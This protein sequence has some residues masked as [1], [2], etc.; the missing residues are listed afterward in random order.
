MQQLILVDENDLPVGLMEKMKVHQL[1][2]MHRAFSVFIFNMEGEML[3]QQIALTKY[4][5]GGLWTN[6]C[7]SHPYEGQEIL[8][9]AKQRL[10]EEMGFTTTIQK[11]FHFKYKASFE[12]G[13]TENEFDH[14]FVGLYNGKIKPDAN[15]V[16]DYCY[17]AVEV[18]RRDIDLHPEKYT[19]WF[20]IAFPLIENY[21]AENFNAI[22]TK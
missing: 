12:N 19:E 21:L 7:C 15:E 1:G 18:V 5:S 4:H 9:A 2:I 17:M 10:F 11:A 22:F 16:E 20:K 13:L 8:H 14:V 3:L 6:A